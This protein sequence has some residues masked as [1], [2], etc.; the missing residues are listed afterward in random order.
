MPPFEVEQSGVRAAPATAPRG[1]AAGTDGEGRAPAWAVGPAGSPQPSPTPPQPIPPQPTPPQPTS[2]QP[3]LPPT[4]T[5]RGADLW[6]KEL[7]DRKL[8]ELLLHNTGSPRR[9]VT[10]AGRLLDDFGD[11]QSLLAATSEQLARYPDLEDAVVHQ[12]RLAQAIAIRAAR[13]RMSEALVL[14]RFDD[15]VDYLRM[16]C[17]TAPIE[18]LWAV[19]LNTKYG[20][21]AD[22]EHTRGTINHTPAYPREIVKRALELGAAAVVLVHN[23]PSGDAT[24]SRCDIRLTAKVEAALA[25]VDIRL[26]DHIIITCREVTS[27]AALGHVG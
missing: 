26:I 19:F 7:S 10:L 5:L 18:L 23:H 9:V 6:A 13:V 1:C 16:R 14:G 12:L 20:L 24:P 15:M 4:V 8:L 27:L 2:T 17:G 22:E 3:A 21:I 11:I 25:T